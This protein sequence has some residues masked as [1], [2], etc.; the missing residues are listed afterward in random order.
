M[1]KYFETVKIS[2]SSNLHALV[3]EPIDDSCQKQFLAILSCFSKMNS[4]S[5]YLVYKIPS[6]R[7]SS[8]LPVSL[9]IE[10]ESSTVWRNLP[11]YFKKYFPALKDPK[12]SSLASFF[13]CLVSK[14]HLSLLLF[15]VSSP[16]KS[17]LSKTA[18][19]CPIQICKPTSCGLLYQDTFSVFPYLG[20]NYFSWKWF[21]VSFK[22]VTSSP[23]DLCNFFAGHPCS[24]PRLAQGYKWWVAMTWYS[25]FYLEITWSLIVLCVLF[26]LRLWLCICV[27]S[28]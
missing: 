26:M 13:N 15:F 28:S 23:L 9:L 4:T 27:C 6:L 19:F 14:K 17:C 11:F 22:L 20:R 2:L 10:F 5:I 1:G 7:M 16:L 18:S 3:V 12:F 25:F 8:A 24:P 21:Q